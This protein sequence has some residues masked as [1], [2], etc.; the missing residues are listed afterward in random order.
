[1]EIPAWAETLFE[2]VVVVFETPAAGTPLEHVGSMDLL[3]WIDSLLVEVP[4]LIS[5]L[6]TGVFPVSFLTNVLGVAPDRVERLPGLLTFFVIFYLLCGALT[7]VLRFRQDQTSLLSVPRQLCNA[8]LCCSVFLFLPMLK[9]VSA[10]GFGGSFYP[11]LALGVVLFSIGIPLA[12]VIRYVW[13]YRFTGIPHAIFDV[14][15]GPFVMAVQ[16][17]CAHKGSKFLCLFIFLAVAALVVLHLDSYTLERLR[18]LYDRLTG[19]P[20]RTPRTRR[21]ED[22]TPAP[23][24]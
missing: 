3:P 5:S 7:M 21:S 16:L 9:L 23:K 17:L 2:K 1:V 4:V 22:D 12:S 10:G 6:K 18:S 14:G 11:L 15:F 20:K 13:V 24:P 19:A 8:I